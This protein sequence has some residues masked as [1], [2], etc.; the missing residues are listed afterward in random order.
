MV[1]I[2][3]IINIYLLNFSS[4]IFP[5]F[6]FI[7]FI[8]LKKLIFLTRYF[9]KSLKTQFIFDWNIWQINVINEIVTFNTYLII[10]VYCGWFLKTIPAN[11]Q[12]KFMVIYKCSWMMIM[13]IPKYNLT[14]MTNI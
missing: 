1:L 12:E 2:K 6:Q 4:F 14:K 5:R 3:S 9:I 11:S 7:N 13:N 10:N 8:I